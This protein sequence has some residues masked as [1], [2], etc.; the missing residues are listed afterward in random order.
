[1]VRYQKKRWKQSRQQPSLYMEELIADAEPLAIFV[2]DSD[3][4]KTD[5][6][7]W[8]AFLPAKDGERSFFRVS[9]LSEA[10]VAEIG[11]REAATRQDQQ[12]QGW[13]EILGSDVRTR[14]PLWLKVVEPPPRH[15]VILGWP[16]ESQDKKKLAMA[17]A[18]VAKTVRCG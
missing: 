15:G 1:M 7:H 2:Y 18:G 6:A 5:G 12:L 3:K 11:H 16:A 17:L 8:K 4:M 10:Q 9:E 14:P 13:A